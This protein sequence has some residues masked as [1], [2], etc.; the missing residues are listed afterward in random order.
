MEEVNESIK[1]NNQKIE[2]MEAD[3]KEKERNSGAKKRYKN[4]K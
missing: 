4:F 3:R 1:F 2:E